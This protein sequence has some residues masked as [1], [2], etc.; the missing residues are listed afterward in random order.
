MKYISIILLTAFT[1]SLTAQVKDA[2]VE[3]DKTTM[4]ALQM[5]IDAD[6]KEV[7]DVWENFWDDR[8]DV[9]FDKL[10]KDRGSIAMSAE[11][12]TV[13]I[14]SPKNANLFAKTGGTEESCRVS[15]AIAYTAN[16]VVTEDAHPKAYSAARAI[17]LEF[18]TFFYTQ[19]FDEKLSDA[20]DDLED[21]RDDSSDASKDAKKARGKIKKYE[22]KIAKYRDKIDKM[23]EEVGDELET[24][25]EKANRAKELEQK[26]RK[27]EQLRAR[28]LG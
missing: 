27:L 23:R 22:E 10:D 21:I 17:M 28:Y 2:R 24:A 15:F 11:Q 1:L 13:P 12:A 16:D 19:Y 5:D 20:R 3:F 9:D 4:E 8:Y 18:R 6:Y 26:I 25:E 7:A 14:I